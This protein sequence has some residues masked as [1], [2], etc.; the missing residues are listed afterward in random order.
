M[1]IKIINF[2]GWAPKRAHPDD[3][4]ADC[5]TL[6]RIVIGAH[7][8]VCVPLGIGVE[9][10]KR[11]VGFILPRSSMASRGLVAQSVPIDPGYQGC[12]HAIVTNYGDTEQIIEA[13][14]RIAQLVILRCWV[15]K[16][17]MIQPRKSKR[18]KRGY[19]AFGST[20]K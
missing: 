15:G 14:D 4:G 7:E 9:V 17:K 3:A 13:G 16:F 2:D 1:R 11:M 12:V 20:G 6:S 19:G 5:Y 10:P 8:T 18:T